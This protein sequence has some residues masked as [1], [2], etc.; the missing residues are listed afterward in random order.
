MSTTIEQLRNLYDAQA[1]KGI[2]LD[3]VEQNLIR[4]LEAAAISDAELLDLNRR[5]LERAFPNHVFRCPK[6]N[7]PAIRNAVQEEYGGGYSDGHIY[8]LKPVRERTD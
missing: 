7:R 8:L 6:D 1:W 2:E 4:R 3:T 5:L